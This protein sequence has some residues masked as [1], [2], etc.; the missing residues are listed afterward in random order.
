MSCPK[1]AVG[2]TQT[3]LQCGV[4]KSITP[5]I[6]TSETILKLLSTNKQTIEKIHVCFD[7]SND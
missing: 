5:F 7:F 3:T 2:I 1:C 4:G 6:C